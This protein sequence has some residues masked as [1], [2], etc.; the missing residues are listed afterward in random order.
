MGI[1]H[2]ALGISDTKTSLRFYRDLLGLQVTGGSVNHGPEQDG[3]DGLD[4]TMV[5]IT[6]LR[7]V[8]GDLGIEFLNYQQPVGGRNRLDA[9]ITDLCDWII[10]IESSS[11]E[12]QHAAF[13][14]SEWE[15]SCGP[16]VELDSVFASRARGFCVRDPDQHAVVVLGNP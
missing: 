15:G 11:L 4:Q 14:A 5:E 3:L 12:R 7:P 16:L 2:T 9:Q 1:D 13:Q 10:L 8:G 6:S